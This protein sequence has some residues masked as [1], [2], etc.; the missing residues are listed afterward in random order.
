MDAKAK[1]PEQTT[2]FGRSAHRS[3]GSAQHPKAERLHVKDRCQ[4]ISVW[5]YPVWRTS[6]PMYDRWSRGGH[7]KFELS[8]DV[9][10]CGSPT[11]TAECVPGLDPLPRVS[12]AEGLQRTHWIFSSVTKSTVA[13]LDRPLGG[14][15]P[16]LRRSFCTF[17]AHR[18]KLWSCRCLGRT[19][20]WLRG[21]MI[22]M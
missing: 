5:C 15:E 13:S 1:W 20:S 3:I 6:K 2:E 4:I 12:A 16:L 22:W 14:V 7:S 18:G 19:Q 9:M 11:L 17:P 8:L 21:T 10:D